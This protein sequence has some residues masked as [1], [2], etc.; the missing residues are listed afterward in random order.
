MWDQNG[1]FIGLDSF[2]SS[3][4]TFVF[5]ADSTVDFFGMNYREG[6]NNDSEVVMLA[7]SVGFDGTRQ[8]SLGDPLTPDVED[9][10]AINFSEL[11]SEVNIDLEDLN[12]DF[13]D[14]TVT[15]DNGDVIAYV[16]G[17]EAVFGS[18]FND[19]IAGDAEANILHGSDGDDIVLGNGGNDLLLGGAG[20]QDFVIGGAGE[21]VIVELD[22]GT[23][24]GNEAFVSSQG[25]ITQSS[26]DSSIDD[27]VFVVGSNTT[28]KDFDLSTEGVGLAGN[29][30]Q[31]ADIV[32]VQLDPAALIAAGVSADAV[33]S[34]AD[35]VNATAWGAF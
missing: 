27:D 8:I 13:F 21:D 34:Y 26:I 14:V 15:N 22:G 16:G 2:S 10:D 17:A 32:F 6:F 7:G 29:A 12:P 23:V 25:D 30:N 5:N 28:I 11:A 20:S 1:N 18:D 9:W 35:P 3:T 31:A 4:N 24:F 33:L 19:D